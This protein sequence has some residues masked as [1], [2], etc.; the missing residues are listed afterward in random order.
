MTSIAS[1]I[2]LSSAFHGGANQ[3]SDDNAEF[4]FNVAEVP[5]GFA[6]VPTTQITAGTILVGVVGINT[7]PDWPTADPRYS[8]NNYDQQLTAIYTLQADT[9]I[10]GLPG[11]AC[12]NNAAVTSCEAWTYTDPDLSFN[13]IMAILNAQFG[14]SI[15]AYANTTA[16]TFAV[17]VGDPVFDYDRGASTI[18]AVLDSAAAGTE[19]LVL[20]QAGSDSF[21][22]IAPSNLLEILLYN[23]GQGFG[24]FAGEATLAYQNIPGWTFEPGVNI[25]GN[26]SRSNVTGSVASI[27]SDA[28]YTITAR[29]PEPGSV[30]LLGIALLGMVGV[31]GRRRSKN[32]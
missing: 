6:L 20:D 31:L 12:G 21:S 1:A 32:V 9:L 8:A 13:T 29:V 19:R 30:A 2:P 7:F 10:G 5:G 25:I 17:V 23:P 18:D 4:A 16:D 27:F 26:L 3:L 28:S 22:T 15:P 14:T 11:L 24:S